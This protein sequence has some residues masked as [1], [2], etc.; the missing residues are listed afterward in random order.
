MNRREFL[1]TAAAGSFVA[2]GALR[3][4]DERTKAPVIDTHM[5]V[6]AKAGLGYPFPNPYQSDF[7][8]PPHDGTLEML[9]DD[10]DAR[11]CTHAVLVQVIYHGWDNRY[12]A[13]CIR[14]NPDRL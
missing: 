2:S 10:M 1:T 12:V 11:G 7:Q 6:W 8:A 14:R 13:D 4:A 9:M 5:H 3:A